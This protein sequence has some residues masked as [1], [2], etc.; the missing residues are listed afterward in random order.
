MHSL[1]ILLS[2]TALYLYDTMIT[3]IFILVIVI[4]IVL[5][6]VIVAICIYDGDM[7][8]QQASYSARYSS[9]AVCVLVVLVRR[10]QASSA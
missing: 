3:I 8:A 6:V 10:L 7:G 2:Y 5:I 1:L 4:V 9:Q